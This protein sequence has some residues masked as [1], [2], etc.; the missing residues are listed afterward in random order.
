P[1]AATGSSSSARCRSEGRSG[2]WSG[3][4]L[5]ALAAQVFGHVL[6][7]VVEHLGGAGPQLAAE[8]AV[9]LGLLERARDLGVVV[10]AGLLVLFLAPQAALDQV[11]L[12]PFDRIAQ[13][14]ALRVVGGAVLGGIVGRGV[15][16]GAV[17]DPF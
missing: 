11:L 13:R 15:R 16:A 4:Q 1:S 12:E 9:G 10:G 8:R 6:V 5:L 7:D 14:E 17:G 2:S 3:S